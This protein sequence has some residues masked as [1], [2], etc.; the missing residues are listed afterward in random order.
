MQCTL[1]RHSY[2]F[3]TRPFVSSHYHIWPPHIP[4][5]KPVIHHHTC[6]HTPTIHTPHHHLT[7]PLQNSL[8]APSGVLTITDIRFLSLQVMGSHMTHAYQSGVGHMIFKVG[9]MTHAHQS[10]DIHKFHPPLPAELQEVQYFV[11]FLS[12]H[13]L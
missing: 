3:T 7:A 4:S 8:M 12:T 6:P 2:M 5:H 11:F 9:H 13:L 1:N 10:C